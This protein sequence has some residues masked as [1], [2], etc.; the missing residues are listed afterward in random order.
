MSCQ[1]LLD[2]RQC[3]PASTACAPQAGGLHTDWNETHAERWPDVDALIE[4]TAAG[5]HAHEEWTARREAEWWAYWGIPANA[6]QREV[7]FD[8]EGGLFRVRV[9]A[10]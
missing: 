5:D 7:F 2:V 1:P 8:F 10:C 6:K 4:G 9:L 3:L